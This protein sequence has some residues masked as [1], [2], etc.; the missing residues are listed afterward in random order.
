MYILNYQAISS[1]KLYCSE[2]I[3]TYL[4]SREIPVLS[5]SNNGTYVFSATD[6]LSEI[7]EMLPEE[8]RKEFYEFK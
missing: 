5:I 8:Y 4:I 7:I 2:V 3:A 1:R 6:I